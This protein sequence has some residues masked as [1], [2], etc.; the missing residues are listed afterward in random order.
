MLSRVRFGSVVFREFAGEHA[1]G[2]SPISQFKLLGPLCRL[3]VVT[4]A[5]ARP[6]SCGE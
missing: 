2:A 6:E 5:A 3:P 4:S 1:F